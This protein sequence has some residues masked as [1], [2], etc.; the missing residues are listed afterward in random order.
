[1]AHDRRER[2]AGRFPLHVTLRLRA[3]LGTL[4]RF[5]TMAVVRPALF[6]VAAQRRCE[7]RV[8]Q[9][10]VQSNHLHLVVEAGGGV[11]GAIATASAA[12]RPAAHR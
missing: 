9:F 2:F 3:G 6:A 7:F 5:K 10:S 4:R 8:V 12:R 11:P 1:M